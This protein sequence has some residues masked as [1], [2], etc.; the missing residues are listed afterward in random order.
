MFPDQFKILMEMGHG[1]EIVIADA[2]FPGASHANR[3]VRINTG[4]P[5]LLS[6]IM[7]FF[8]L[9]NCVPQPVAL[10][11]VVEGDDYQPVIWEQYL[12]IIEQSN[13][14]LNGFEMLDRFEFYDRAKRAYAVIATTEM[15]RYANVV[16]KKGIIE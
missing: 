5:E 8:P 4:I 16:L 13:L 7:K 12:S 9:D 14:D 2:N 10:M 6:A 15:A 11:Q 1:D 3:L